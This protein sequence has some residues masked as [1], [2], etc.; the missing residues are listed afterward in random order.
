MK[1]A[2]KMKLKAL[3]SS[4]LKGFQLLMYLAQTKECAFKCIKC[5]Q[6][7][8][9]NYLYKI[10]LGNASY[11]ICVDQ[12]CYLGDMLSDSGPAEASSTTQVRIAWKE[13][14]ELLPLLIFRLFSHNL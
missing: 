7:P 9:R 6:L 13:F 4:F 1:R 3:S 10:K 14:N 2:F 12:F 5:L 8:E 11:E